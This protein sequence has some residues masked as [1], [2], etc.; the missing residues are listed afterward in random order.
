MWGHRDTESNWKKRD[1]QNKRDR[2]TDTHTHTHT[3]TNTHTHTHTYTHA[4][5]GKG[6]ELRWGKSKNWK[7][8]GWWLLTV[9]LVTW[10]VEI[11]KIMGSWFK[12]SV[13]K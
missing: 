9:I 10:E 7:F 13:G 5:G 2:K 1:P 11:R 12:A 8:S 6:G 4:H 3:H